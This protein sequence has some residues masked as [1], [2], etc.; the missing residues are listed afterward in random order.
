MNFDLLPSEIWEEI[1]KTN[2]LGPHRLDWDKEFI[3][4]AIAN[5]RRQRSAKK[6]ERRLV[7]QTR[8]AATKTVSLLSRL[9]Q[10]QAFLFIGVEDDNAIAT[11]L[12][13]IVN[14]AE[15]CA[16]IEQEM[17]NAL[18]RFNRAGDQLVFPEYGALEDF[19]FDLLM[20]HATSLETAA[21]TTPHQSARNPGFR[22]LVHLCVRAAA[23]PNV[24][25]DKDEGR[26][27]ISKAIEQATR[28]Y[29]TVRKIDP[30]GWRRNW[31]N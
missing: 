12:D 7:E 20:T 24:D 30:V 22:Q 31:E 16:E 13:R 8:D 28:N 11:T 2:A 23:D 27:K 17:D 18:K 9:V 14:A 19:V 10:E 3:E 4:R 6:D 21:P 1:K 26:Q 5:Y 29:D 25:P 15:A